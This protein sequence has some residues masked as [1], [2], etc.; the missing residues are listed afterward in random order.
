MKPFSEACERNKGPI[1]EA[2]VQYFKDATSV[3]EIG[4]G[5]GQHAAFFALRLPHLQWQ[6]S[7]LKEHHAGIQ[8][9]IK[10]CK[11]ENISQPLELDVFNDKWPEQPYDGIFTANTLHIMPWAAV[12]TLF[13]GVGKSL[14]H[15]GHLVIY[16]PFKY[17]GVLAPESNVKFEAWLKS[18]DPERGV[19]DFEQVDRLAR[20][21]GL[22]L[23][24]DREMP[25]HNRLLV[26]QKSVNW[27]QRLRNRFLT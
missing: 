8:G 23:I 3:L 14:A 17:K 21:A 10:G 22:K 16:G 4:S 25:A 2:L 27:W 9:W 20:Q 5:T 26:Y 11:E 13:Q 1:A 6:P 7:D 24:E 15:S 12:E 18:V 19:R